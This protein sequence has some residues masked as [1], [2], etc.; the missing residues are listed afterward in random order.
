[1]AVGWGPRQAQGASTP[2]C[3]LLLFLLWLSLGWGPLQYWGLM[4]ALVGWVL[5]FWVL[6]TGGWW[7]S[8]PCK[9]STTSNDEVTHTLQWIDM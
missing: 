6:G 2:A 9:Q 1:M 7:Y 4:D 8:H 3:I 5:T